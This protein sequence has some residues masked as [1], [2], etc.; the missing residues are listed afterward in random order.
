MLSFII[1]TAFETCQIALARD[2]IIIAQERATSGGRHDHVLA[3]MTEKLFSAEHVTAA[4]IHLIIVTTGPGRFTG[5]RVGIAF[6]RG[7]ALVHDTKLVGV[8]TTDAILRDMTAYQPKETNTAVLVAVKRGE[9]FVFQNGVITSVPDD[10]LG[11]HLQKSGDVLVA[12][13]LSPAA[14]QILEQGG[15]RTFA[16][17]TEPS[18]AS[19]TALGIEK[20]SSNTLKTPV[21]E[22]VRPFYNA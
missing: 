10:A 21:S 16:A 6:A 13:V 2:G 14:V 3:T 4:D 12:G 19:I 18:L 9:T 17:I 1:D 11:A 22:A 8:R 7:L 5:L 20:A 15:I